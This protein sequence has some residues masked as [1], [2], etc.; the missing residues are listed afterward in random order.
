MVFVEF[1]IEVSVMNLQGHKTGIFVFDGPGP[2]SRR[3]Q[4][5]CSHEQDLCAGSSTTHQLFLI[6]NQ[7]N[8]DSKLTYNTRRKMEA[9][10]GGRLSVGANSPPFEISASPDDAK[11][12]LRQW[13][14]YLCVWTIEYNDNWEQQDYIRLDIKDSDIN[15]V[16]VIDPSRVLSQYNK[17]GQLGG[18][19]VLSS[20]VSVSGI[21]LDIGYDGEH[22]FCESNIS[23]TMQVSLIAGRAMTIVFS[24]YEGYSLAAFTATVSVTH[25][26]GYSQ[27]NKL[28]T[29]YVD[30]KG[31]PTVLC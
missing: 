20:S 31:Y 21:G 10:C 25:C 13:G 19:K 29:Y 9:S 5:I 3:V 1:T 30:T 23:Q 2:L 28:L 12:S 24:V 27:T 17:Y 4:I 11:P 14:N 26:L 7:R 18:L 15:L 22:H 16:S 8:H 6:F